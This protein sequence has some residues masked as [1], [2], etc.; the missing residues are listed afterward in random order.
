MWK[1]ENPKRSVLRAC[2]DKTAT[3]SKRGRTQAE[4]SQGAVSEEQAG[5]VPGCT[6]GHV[7]G[8]GAGGSSNLEPL[9]L[10]PGFA[11][12]PQAKPH[13]EI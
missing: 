2:A 6:G 10:S 8:L 7:T 9:G 5:Q 4:A 3:L 13:P 1:K 11:C 12:R